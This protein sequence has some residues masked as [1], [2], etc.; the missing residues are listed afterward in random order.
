MP[1]LGKLACCPPPIQRLYIPDED[2]DNWITALRE[3][4]FTPDEGKLILCRLSPLYKYRRLESTV[5]YELA[6]VRSSLALRGRRLDPAQE[7]KYRTGIRQRLISQMEN[8]S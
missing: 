3:L 4:G 8:G 1:Q 7:K 5:E 6:G 2:L